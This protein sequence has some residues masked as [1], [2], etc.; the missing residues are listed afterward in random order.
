MNRDTARL[1]GTVAPYLIVGA[2]LAIS[3]GYIFSVTDWARLATP[4]VALS[5]LKRF[6]PPSIGEI[7]GLFWPTRGRTRSESGLNTGGSWPS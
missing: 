6:F 5:N 1:A 7:P 2:G 4:E 3:A